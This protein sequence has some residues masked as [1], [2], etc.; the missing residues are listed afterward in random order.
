MSKILLKIK[1][2]EDLRRITLDEKPSYE[3]LVALLRSLFS[4]DLASNTFA[5]KYVDDENDLITISHDREVSEAWEFALNAG[6]SRPLLR[7]V[8][9]NK[10]PKQIEQKSEPV[11]EGKGKEKIEE[12]QQETPSTTSKSTGTS[13]SS[14]LNDVLNIPEVQQIMGALNLD[15]EAIKPCLSFLDPMLSGMSAHTQ[16]Q[17]SSSSTTGEEKPV[18]NATCDACN[19]TIVGVRYKCNACPDYDLCEQCEPKS[20]TIHFQSHSF[21]KILKPEQSNDNTFGCRFRR[22]MMHHGASCDVCEQRIVGQRYKCSNCPDYDLC[23][24][25]YPNAKNVH[26]NTHIFNLVQ[27]QN[28]PLWTRGGHHGWGRRCGGGWRGNRWES[29]TNVW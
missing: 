22:Q 4:E 10:S 1:L 14:V 11:L 16:S 6:S 20:P 3:A 17:T 5:V 23:E 8:I 24:K 21:L 19:K 13:T 12:S 29:S 27:C 28:V 9:E 2:G 25:C 26:D 18:H 15:P 7:L